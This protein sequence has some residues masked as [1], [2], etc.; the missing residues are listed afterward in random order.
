MYNLSF[1]FC[2]AWLL[3]LASP[4]QDL[5]AITSAE[6]KRHVG[7]RVKVCGILSQIKEPFRR[8]GPTYLNFE[9]KYPR[10][11]FA[12]VIWKWQRHRFV[13]LK[14]RIGKS[15]C[16]VGQMK[17]YEGRAQITLTKTEQLTPGF[18]K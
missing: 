6:A 10:N 15:I 17:E 14:A 18:D 12:A 7:E 4:P 11:E 1:L 2:W 3:L 9:Q 5:T 8:S 16:V 13:D